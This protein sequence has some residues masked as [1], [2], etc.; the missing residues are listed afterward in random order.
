MES[1]DRAG[2]QSF[3]DLC[4]EYFSRC[5][6][7]DQLISECQGLQDVAWVVF[8]QLPEQSLAWLHREIPALGGGVPVALLSSGRADEVRQCLWR[9]P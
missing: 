7:Q 1:F 8:Y 5:T 6:F 9:M 4:K 2:W 3:A